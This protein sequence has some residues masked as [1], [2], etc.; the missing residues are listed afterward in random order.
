MALAATSGRRARLL[1]QRGDGLGSS[2]AT[3]GTVPMI[4]PGL[5]EQPKNQ[6]IQLRRRAVESLAAIDV[7]D[8]DDPATMPPDS[9]DR[10]DPITPVANEPA[11]DEL[12]HIPPPY[13]LA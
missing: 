9:V 13:G 8:L 7:L 11:F 2:G 4:P 3:L 12:R 10:L 5:A 1:N 6:S